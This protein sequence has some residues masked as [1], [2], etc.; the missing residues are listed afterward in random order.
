MSNSSIPATGSASSTGSTPL[1]YLGLL[2]GLSPL[3][4]DPN[5]VINAMLQADQIPINNLQTQIKNIQTNESI[6]KSIGADISALQA[7]AFNLTLQSTVQAN[8]VT[9]SNSTAVSATAGPQVQAGTYTVAVNQVATA[10]AAQSTAPIGQ[11]IASLASTTPLNSLNLSAAP[12]S[13]AFSVIVDGRVQTVNVDPTKPLVDAP[14]TT[15]PQGALSRLQAAITAGLSDGA[16]T[17]NVGVTGDKVSI[18][19][20]GAS[21]QHTISFGAS[22]DTSNFLSLMNL[23]TAQGTTSGGALALTSSA[24][25]GVAQPNSLLSA[26]ALATA[27]TGPAGAS[28]APSGTF[29]INGVSIA[30]DSG[31]DSLTSVVNK[32]NNS[33]AGVTAQYNAVTDQLSLASKSTGQT[34]ISLSDTTGNFLAAMHLAPGTT[35]AQTL[36]ANASVTVNGTPVTSAS[37]TITNAVPGLSIT[38]LASTGTTPATLTV[39]ADTKDITTQV[40]S[41]VTAVNKVLS[42]ISLTQQKDPTTGQYSQLLGD[43]TLTGIVNNLL[44]TITGSVTSTGAYQSLQDIGITTGPVGS[45]PGTTNALQLDT[46]KLSAALAANPGQVAAI[47]NGTKTTNGFQGVAQQLNTY[48]TQL[49]NPVTGSFAEYQITSDAQVRSMQS[50]ITFLN[51][52]LAE[53]R[54]MLTAQFTTM[55]TTLSNLAS[56]GSLFSAF[57]NSGTSTSSPTTSSSSSTTGGH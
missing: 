40:Q 36:G 27:L 41:F 51:Q 24:N 9:S 6:Y 57:S 49:A 18:N 39:G 23:T 25:V 13:G 35:T 7:A 50:Q 8:T 32:I 22:G 52:M 28:G 10:T 33:A 48:L 55:G 4:F 29:S 56:Q 38:A 54:Q 47:F 12:T 21:T 45:Q 5:S 19:I 16:A 53:Q 15:P 46:N 42:D 37:N 44:T 2:G 31:S 43:P 34:A 30:W 26:A 17:V 1:D 20:S 14:G 11:S 3:P